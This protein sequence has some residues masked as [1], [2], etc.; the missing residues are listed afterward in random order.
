MDDNSIITEINFGIKLHE[1]KDALRFGTDALLLFSYIR[2]RSRAKSAEFGAGSGAVSLLAAKTGKLSHCDCVEINHDLACLCRKN[3]EQNGLG[4][5]LSVIEADCRS[6]KKEEKYDYI[7]FN[8]PYF[9]PDSGK[10]NE[11]V[12]KHGARHAKEGDIIDFCRAASDTVKFGGSVYIVYRPERMAELLYALSE[13]KLEPKRLTLVCVQKDAA[14]SLILIEAKKGAS[15]GIFITKP[16]VMQNEDG[17][18]SADMKY[19]Y[20][21]GEFDVDFKNP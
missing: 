14:P 1:R 13:K 11:S 6:L 7:F 2:A 15:H 3:I 17:S 5:K 12:I 21:N 20:Q 8:P 18:D 19:I 9:R 4:E 10:D 16:L